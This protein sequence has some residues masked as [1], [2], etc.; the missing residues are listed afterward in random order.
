MAGA[1]EPYEGILHVRICGGRRGQPRLLPGSERGRAAS[2]VNADTLG[3]PRRSVSSLDIM[4][5]IDAAKFLLVFTSSFAIDFALARMPRLAEHG[6]LPLGLA[7]IWIP[8]IGYYLV[9]LSL[10]AIKEFRRSTRHALAG[11]IA[12]VLIVPTGIAV[13]LYGTTLRGGQFTD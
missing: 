12:L 9:A 13:L 10:P 8:V 2:V 7:E 11:L 5:L 1:D 3:R 4:R 6:G